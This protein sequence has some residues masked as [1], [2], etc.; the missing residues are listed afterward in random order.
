MKNI[1]ALVLVVFTFTRAHANTRVFGSLTYLQSPHIETCR[2]VDTPTPET[3]IVE[4]LLDATFGWSY[5][6]GDKN[7]N[8]EP[9]NQWFSQRSKSGI[10]NIVY[11]PSAPGGDTSEASYNHFYVITKDPF[12]IDP[13]AISSNPKSPYIPNKKIYKAIQISKRTYW[14]ST[15]SLLTTEEVQKLDISKMKVLSSEGKKIISALFNN[16]D[17]TRI[18]GV[19]YTTWRM[20]VPQIQFTHTDHGIEIEFSVA[21]EA[22]GSGFT[23]FGKKVKIQ[24]KPGPAHI[25]PDQYILANLTSVSDNR[26]TFKGF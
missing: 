11:A 6:T 13:R 4:A 1:F 25:N 19:S 17:L 20:R 18:I 23:G 12:Y 2:Y 5:S 26:C 21:E 7:L 10:E 3:Y 8:F 24:S 14:H 9:I 22:G 15:L 16:E